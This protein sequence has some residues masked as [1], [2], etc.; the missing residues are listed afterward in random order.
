M[1][2]LKIKKNFFES[3]F[4]MAVQAGRYYVVGVFLVLT[5]FFVSSETCKCSSIK[6]EDSKPEQQPPEYQ[7]RDLQIPESLQLES[8]ELEPVNPEQSNPEPEKFEEFDESDRQN[9]F[10]RGL[11]LEDITGQAKSMLVSMAKL[12]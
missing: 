12:V 5:T 4:R 3:N 2:V 8:Q 7:S 9:R 6:T 10:R 11:G 1:T